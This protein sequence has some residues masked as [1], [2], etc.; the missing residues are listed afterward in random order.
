MRSTLSG[1]SDW[2]A[3]EYHSIAPRK[4]SVWGK[5][6][7]WVLFYFLI[8]RSLIWRKILTVGHSWNVWRRISS[9]T[10]PWM[11]FSLS[12]RSGSTL[13][14]KLKFSTHIQQIIHSTQMND[15]AGHLKESDVGRHHSLSLRNLSFEFISL[16]RSILNTNR[17]KEFISIQRPRL[18]DA[19][20]KKNSCSDGISDYISSVANV[21]DHFR[22]DLNRGRKYWPRGDQGVW[23]CPGWCHFKTRASKSDNQTLWP[24]NN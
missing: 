12:V 21:W 15:H 9:N 16:S 3:P 24:T 8:K 6:T 23:R 1:F 5:V 13:Q 17:Q 14:R 18:F 2:G 10:L 20:R 22:P 11:G 4:N 7:R 19:A